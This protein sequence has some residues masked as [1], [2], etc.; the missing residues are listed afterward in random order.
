MKDKWRGEEGTHLVA[1]P[2]FRVHLDNLHPRLDWGVQPALGFGK[3]VIASASV[4]ASVSQSLKKD[5]DAGGYVKVD[6]D[7]VDLTYCLMGL[8]RDSRNSFVGK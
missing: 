2:P 8:R 7:L 5:A 6:R 3:T 1:V 4:I